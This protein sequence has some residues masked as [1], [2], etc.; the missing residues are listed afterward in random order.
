MTIRP[1]IALLLALGPIACGTSV[2]KSVANVER[3]APAAVRDAL[4]VAAVKTRVAAADVDSAAS[5]GVRANDGH[6]TLTGRVRTIAQR[7]TVE[8]AARGVNGVSGVEDQV[9]IDPAFRGVGQSASDF[10]LE[11]RVAG[12]LAT[13]TGVNAL[14][15]RTHARGGTVVLEGTVPTDA[16]KT[17]M[18]AT[19]RSV[20]GVRSLSDRLRVRP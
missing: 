11:A 2:D 18:L 14:H 9:G 19:A 15:V 7:E 16:V 5:I 12:A 20:S 6:V 8:R 17:T 3:Q 10:G 1:W 13:Q 4:L